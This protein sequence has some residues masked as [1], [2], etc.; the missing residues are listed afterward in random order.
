MSPKWPELMPEG[1]GLSESDNA[2]RLGRALLTGPTMSCPQTLRITQVFYATN[3]NDAPE[4][5]VWR[6][7]KRRASDQLAIESLLKVARRAPVLMPL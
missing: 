4:N 7:S 2:S 3:N 6:D 1:G 5:D